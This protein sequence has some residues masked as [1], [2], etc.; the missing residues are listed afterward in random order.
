M[1]NLF[2]LSL[3]V[4]P[5]LADFPDCVNG[6]AILTSNLVCSTNASV[7]DRAAAIVA[8]MSTDEK[9]ASMGNGSPGVDR[10]G[11][12]AYEWWQVRQFH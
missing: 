6:P 2:F 11:L 8:V 7:H 4:L 12:P 1:A 10:L 3:L 5:A 9:L